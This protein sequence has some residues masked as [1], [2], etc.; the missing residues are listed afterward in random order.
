MSQPFQLARMAVDEI[1]V[2]LPGEGDGEAHSNIVALAEEYGTA[3][4]YVTEDEILPLGAASL[5]I[6]APVGDGSSNEEG[7]SVLSTVGDFDLLLTGDMNRGSEE[8][9]LAHTAL[10]DL[11]VLVVG[12]H[13]S[14]TSC[15]E[16]FLDALTPEAGII[17]V[18]RNSYGHPTNETLQRLVR[19]G[20]TVYRTD[21]Q[22][23]LSIL[24]R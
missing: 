5:T 14:R 8:A 13:G 15:G 22:G 23:D 16:E 18:G 20:M 2:P 21:L 3:L 9:L 6:F 10:P 1:L 24:V 19:R 4:R 11:E 12:H 17:S 7:L